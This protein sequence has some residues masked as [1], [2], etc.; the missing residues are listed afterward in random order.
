MAKRPA[1]T[2]TRK[3]RARGMMT[4]YAHLL[5]S[6]LGAEVEKMLPRKKEP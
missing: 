2:L 5:D 6:D 3:N 4:W 1:A